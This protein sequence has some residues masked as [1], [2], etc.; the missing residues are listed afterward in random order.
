MISQVVGAMDDHLVTQNA[1]CDRDDYLQLGWEGMSVDDCLLRAQW[2]GAGTCTF[3]AFAPYVPASWEPATGKS[4]C[5]CFHSCDKQKR[6]PMSIFS[7]VAV[8]A[9]NISTTAFVT[10]TPVAPAAVAIASTSAPAFVFAQ[11]APNKGRCRLI[12]YRNI[13]A[14]AI[15][16]EECLHRANVLKRD[17]SACNFVSHSSN[18]D[19]WKCVCFET[20]DGLLDVVV[21]EAWNSWAVHGTSEDFDMYD[22]TIVAGSIGGAFC[23]IGMIAGF[24]CACNSFSKSKMGKQRLSNTDVIG[25]RRKRFA[26]IQKPSDQFPSGVIGLRV[27]V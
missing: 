18:N 17:G 22:Y 6:S 5:R 27:D 23:A 11:D 2:I 15:S 3:F 10:S 21:G 4:D 20:C 24:A 16:Q 26:N 7:L 8:P 13:S 19:A 1:V 14:H 25:I 9:S 12:D